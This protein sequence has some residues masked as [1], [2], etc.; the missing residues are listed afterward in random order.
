MILSKVDD[1]PTSTY[2]NANWMQGFN[3]E[4]EYILTQGPLGTTILDFWRMVWESESRVVVMIA[5]LMEDGRPKC[6]QYWAD[7]DEKYKIA[8]FILAWDD[9]EAYPFFKVTTMRLGNAEVR[10]RAEWRV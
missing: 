7:R 3:H 6:V 5:R 2:I 8:N 4:K 1:D 9:T 10:S